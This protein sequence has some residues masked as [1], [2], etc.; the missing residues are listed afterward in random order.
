MSCGLFLVRIMKLLLRHNLIDFC[1]DKCEP[2]LG[3]D[4]K[5]VMVLVHKDY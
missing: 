1:F 5:G 4:E 2:R 3:K